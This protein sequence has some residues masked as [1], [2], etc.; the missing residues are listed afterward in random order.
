MHKYSVTKTP[1]GQ[2]QLLVSRLKGVV[3]I[4]VRAQ[5]HSHPIRGARPLPPLRLRRVMLQATSDG[6]CIFMHPNRVV[7]LFICALNCEYNE[8]KLSSERVL[9]SDN[10]GNL[11]LLS[12][13]NC[14]FT[15]IQT[16]KA[17]K[18][19]NMAM[20]VTPTSAKTASHNV[21][22]PAAL[23][24]STAALTAREKIMF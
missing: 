18:E 16:F 1:P 10:L 4:R 12:N 23:R 17:R 3:P 24:M 11:W 8:H 19:F 20:M 2:H 13:Q 22:R 7:I 6:S 15:A 21:A 5:C 9:I 14:R